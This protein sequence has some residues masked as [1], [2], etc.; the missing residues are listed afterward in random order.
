MNKTVCKIFFLLF[1]ACSSS[2]IFSQNQKIS[3]TSLSHFKLD[4]DDFLGYDSFGYSYQI[5]NNVF[6][7]TKGN[8]VFEY[9]SISLGNIT[10]VDLQNPLKIVLY[11]DDFN[12]VLLLDNQLNKITEINFSQNAIPIVV[13]AIGMST[14]NQLWV[15]NALNQQIGLFDYLKNE[16]KTVSTPL[17]ETIKYYQ[18]DFNTFYWIDKKNNWFSCNIFGKTTS[19]GKVS[20]FDTIEI[21]NAHQYIFSKGNLLYFK[22]IT[23]TNSSTISEIEILEKTFDKFCYKDQILS[24]FTAKGITNYKIVTP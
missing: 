10:K 2:A 18:T 8:E 16:Y 21:I 13:N 24:I 22:D 15:Y 20:D 4:A 6:S 19:L 5:K 12:T 9:K 14:Q 1:I 17:T 3:A 23:D 7:K 11:Y